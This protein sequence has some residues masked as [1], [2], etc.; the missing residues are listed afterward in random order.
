M[1]GR[2]CIFYNTIILTDD[3][4]DWYKYFYMDYKLYYVSVMLLIIDTTIKKW[5][6]TL[7]FSFGV[8][9]KRILSDF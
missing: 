3:T 5:F 1:E 4:P 8:L 9:F 6:V 2:T 7:Y